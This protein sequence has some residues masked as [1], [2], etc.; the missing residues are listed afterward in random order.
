MSPAVS[1]TAG[2]ALQ[3]VSEIPPAS[4]QALRPQYSFERELISVEAT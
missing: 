3:S 1:F 4:Q 2:N